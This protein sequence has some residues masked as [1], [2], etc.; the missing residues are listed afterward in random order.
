MKKRLIFDSILN[1]KN[2][3]KISII[4]GPRQ[5]G[6]TTILE[7]LHR[8]LG[9]VF[10]D[11][12]IFSNYEKISTYEKFI[13]LIQLKGYKKN[14]KS[15]FYVF[16]DEFQRYADLT[17]IMKNIYDHHNNI[18]IYASGS[19]SLLIKNAIQESL[20]GRK[21][22]THLYPLSF[23]EFL[24]FKE[25]NDLLKEI[26]NLRKIETGEY[27]QLIPEAFKYLNEFILFGGYPEVALRET[28][29]EKIE[30]LQ[31]IF[32]LY[33]KKDL[34]NFLQ[35]KMIDSAH[36][37]IKQLAINNGTMANYSNYGMKAGI[38]TKTVKNYIRLLKETFLVVRLAPYFTNKNKEITKTPKIYFLDNGVRNYFLNNFNDLELR[39]DAGI[40]FEGF[41][42]SEIIKSGENPDNIKYY[43]T[44]TGN[45]VDVILDRVSKII[46]IEI[47][48]KR[49]LKE[50]DARG[51]NKFIKKYGI[52]TGYLVNTGEI[53]EERDIKKIDCFNIPSP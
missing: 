40:L 38:D 33:I 11:V 32:D 1:Q 50:S 20:A 52:L 12:D 29:E 9:G 16:L 28:R 53:D 21:Q 14:Q 4:L 35:P 13:N 45:E 17:I 39:N 24:I 22:I 41:Y 47:K 6:K 7:E 19:S 30:A 15:F 51:L 25:R 2:S 37:L 10:L 31:S 27:H 3:K 44:K 46:P 23:R 42:I 5:A 36:T 48:H 26:E 49:K 34:V 43:R 18:K 8:K